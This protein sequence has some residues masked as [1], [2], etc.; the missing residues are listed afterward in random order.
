MSDWIRPE[1][2]RAALETG[3]GRGV[4][5]A[6]LDSGIETAHPDFLGRQLTDDVVVEFNQPM[7]SGQGEDIYGHG[8]AIAG[9]IW[10]LAP[11]A[12]IGSFRVLGENL[13]AR[14]A[15]ISQ[16]AVEAMKRGYHVLNCSFG[17]G[18]SA[19]M[20]LYKE[21]VDRACLSGV[22]VV[23]A[24]CGHDRPEW[25]ADFTS[26]LGVDCSEDVSTAPLY[27]RTGHL[28]EF[29][30]PSKEEH[31]AWKHGGHRVMMGSSF[32][33][34]HLSGLLARLLS[35]YPLRDPLLAKALLRQLFS[36]PR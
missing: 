34:A 20:P 10:K 30:A 9:I 35:V 14:S 8:T 27:H 16:A 11:K 18:I 1:E 4:R 6:V 2:A 25:P 23:A 15:Q 13:R 36:R 3:D 19:H 24:S 28:V 17:C 22:H 31:V 7:A 12:E 32:A 5:I 33:A 29:A 26:V 21:W